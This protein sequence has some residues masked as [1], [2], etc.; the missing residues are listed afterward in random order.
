MCVLSEIDYFAW[1]RQL[2]GSYEAEVT[3]ISKGH[4]VTTAEIGRL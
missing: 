3:S 1:V 2:G 4:K